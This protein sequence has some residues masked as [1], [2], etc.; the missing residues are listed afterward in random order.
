MPEQNFKRTIRKAA[1]VAITTTG[2]LLSV[3]QISSRLPPSP[4]LDPR[5]KKQLIHDFLWSMIC[6]GLAVSGPWTY[7]REDSSPELDHVM[8]TPEGHRA[9]T[10]PQPMAEDHLGLLGKFDTMVGTGFD[11]HVR[12]AYEHALLLFQVPLY[13]SGCAVLL[14]GAAERVLVELV[15]VTR[16]EPLQEDLRLRVFND[17]TQA[18]TDAWNQGLQIRGKACHKSYDCF[19]TFEECCLTHLP[20]VHT[21]LRT[22]RNRGAHSTRELTRGQLFEGLFLFPAYCQ[23]ILHLIEWI[24]G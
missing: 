14:G 18:I 3:E 10:A 4:T 7:H 17:G 21:L 13:H 2:R 5:R 15:R 23:Q 9:L 24:R 19:E 12:V 1:A 8:L 6:E 22:I 11:G 20:R 16:I